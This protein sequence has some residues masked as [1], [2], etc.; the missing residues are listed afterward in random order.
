MERDAGQGA[1]VPAAHTGPASG[2]SA[3][4]GTRERIPGLRD[5]YDRRPMSFETPMK[6]SSSTIPI[7]T[8]ETRS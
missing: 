3:A 1:E 6:K 2:I 4:W 7:P 5:D 8:I